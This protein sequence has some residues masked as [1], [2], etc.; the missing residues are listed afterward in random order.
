MTTPFDPPSTFMRKA[1]RAL[2]GARLLLEAGDLEGASSR[3][4]YAMFDAARAALVTVRPDLA[5]GIKTHRGLIG[6]FGEHV[7]LSGHVDAALGRTLNQA[8]KL[9]LMADYLG[10]PLTLDDARWAV[11]EAE[12]FLA[13][14]GRCFPTL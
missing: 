2:T 13:E 10:D 14:I 8:E 4:Y 12:Q 6:A 9:R 5:G 7:V 3:A 11:S 1:E